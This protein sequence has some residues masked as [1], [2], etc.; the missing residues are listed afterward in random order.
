VAPLTADSDDGG[1]VQLRA[2]RL[3][4]V[5]DRCFAAEFQTCLRGGAAEPLYQ[6]AI[7]PGQ[8]NI[9]WYRED[10]FASAL[11]EVAHWCIAGD[12]RRRQVDFGYWYAPDGRSA[13]QQ[14]AFE[15]VETEPQALEWFFSLACDYR[16]TLSADNLD[17]DNGQL[18]DNGAFQLRV[19]DRAAR[20]QRTGLPDRA[21]RFYNALCKEFGTTASINSLSFCRESLQ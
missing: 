8:L 4:R 9:L 10:F 1:G 12:K 19:V 15:V 20:W 6:P 7:E 18:P 17:V 21:A 2:E 11:H 3:E 14:A 16:F 13:Q 5:F